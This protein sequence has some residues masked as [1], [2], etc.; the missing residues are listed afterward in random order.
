[1]GSQP[2]KR[3]ADKSVI[4]RASKEPDC[5]SDEPGGPYV[6]KRRS[7]IFFPF[8]AVRRLELYVAL[9][10]SR[11]RGNLVISQLKRYPTGNDPEISGEIDVE[12]AAPF[13]NNIVRVPNDELVVGARKSCT[14]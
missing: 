8:A 3:Q 9:R 11:C 14:F 4:C 12:V 1:M 7:R 5:L 13:C 6:F 10:G 2:A